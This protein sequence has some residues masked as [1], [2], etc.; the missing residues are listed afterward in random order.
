M[1]KVQNKLEQKQ[2]K[3]T[4]KLFLFLFHASISVDCMEFYAPVNPVNVLQEINL[5]LDQIA[6]EVARIAAAT[7]NIRI[8]S[9]NSRI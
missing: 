1:L 9:R 5:H 4:R 2:W 3:G 7:Q 8:I 6:V